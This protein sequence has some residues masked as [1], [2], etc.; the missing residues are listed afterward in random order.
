MISSIYFPIRFQSN[1]MEKK[2]QTI[3]FKV[4]L[5]E[6]YCILNYQLMSHE[7]PTNSFISKK[8]INFT[9]DLKGVKLFK[10]N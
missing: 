8:S 4:D 1:L 2:V 7:I 6:L 10:I 3:N 9:S 5:K